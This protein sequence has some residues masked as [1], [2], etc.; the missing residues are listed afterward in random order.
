MAAKKKITRK[1]FFRAIL[2]IFIIPISYVWNAI[3][4]REVNK[5]RKLKEIHIPNDL[6]QGVTF[7]E[8]MII[9]KEGRQLK[10][11]SS[12]CTHLGCTI[13]H[14]ENNN[15]VCSCHGSRFNFDGDVVTG[16]A[17]NHLKE[18]PFRIDDKAG[19]IIVTVA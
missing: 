15:L 5:K 19:E 12:K 17:Q 16:P 6:S 3:V 2:W 9:L 4:E 18:L 10:V 7:Y 13:K 14:Q 1:Q 8:L 11:F